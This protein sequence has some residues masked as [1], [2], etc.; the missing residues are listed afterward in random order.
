MS[1]LV[2][3]ISRKGTFV[4]TFAQLKL[5]YLKR[6]EKKEFPRNQNRCVMFTFGVLLLMDASVL[7]Q[8]NSDLSSLTRRG[9][10]QGHK[11]LFSLRHTYRPLGQR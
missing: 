4:F 8:L 11:R 9:C 10:R 7:Q 2:L 6:V 5:C 1:L 3:A